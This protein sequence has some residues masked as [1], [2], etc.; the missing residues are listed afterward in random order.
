MP[1]LFRTKKGDTV[2]RRVRQR[3][4]SISFSREDLADLSHLLAV[5]RSVL[6]TTPPV[7]SRLKAAMTRMKVPVAKGL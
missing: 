7:V 5:G 4:T 1:R 3:T 6:Q 2:R